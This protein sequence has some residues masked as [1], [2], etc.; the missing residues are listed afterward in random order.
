MVNLKRFVWFMALGVFVFLFLKYHETAR[1]LVGQVSFLP[2]ICSVV[3]AIA[4]G[5]LSVAVWISIIRCLEPETRSIATKKLFGIYCGSLLAKYIPGGVWEISGRTYLM[6]REGVDA[7]SSLASIAYELLLSTGVGLLLVFKPNVLLRI[8]NKLL[9]R[10]GYPIP[11]QLFLPRREI[12][13]F[14]AYYVGIF[15][16]FGLAYAVFLHSLFGFFPASIP[17]LVGSWILA[18]I[19]GVIVFFA[20]AGIGVRDVVLFFFLQQNIPAQ[21]AALVTTGARLVSIAAEC[22]LYICAAFLGLFPK[23]NKQVQNSMK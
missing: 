3:L 1:I 23:G 6:H 22:I 15:I 8:A 16:I 5:A 11:E 12:L 21:E 17:I 4:G 10:F 14:S 19:L 20:P 9:A 18:M 7:R 2:L 13:K